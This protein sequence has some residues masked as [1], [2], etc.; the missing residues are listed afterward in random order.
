MKRE[1]FARIVKRELARMGWSYT[2]LANRL[3]KT[4]AAVSLMLSKDS[5]DVNPTIIHDY[6][7]ALEVSVDIFFAMEVDSCSTSQPA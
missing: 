5:G 7:K 2:E 3:G 6:A 1:L 4:S